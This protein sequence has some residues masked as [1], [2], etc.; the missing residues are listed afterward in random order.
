MKRMLTAAILAVLVFSL[1]SFSAS[2][3]SPPPAPWFIVTL[4]SLP[5]GTVYVDMLISLPE[6]DPCYREINPENLPD[7]FP[8]DAEIIRYC[9]DGYRSY[10]FH[11]ADA[12]SDITPGTSLTVTFCHDPSGQRYPNHIEDIENRGD[13]RL[14]ML[15]VNGNILKVSA[16]TPRNQH[17]FLASITNTFYYN[18]ATDTLTRQTESLL[19]GFLGVLLLIGCTIA[20]TVILEVVTGLA[21]GLKKYSWMILRVNLVSQV[22]M[23][24]LFLIFAMPAFLTIPV[25]VALEIGIY[26]LEYL[27]YRNQIQDVT[28]KKCL[29]Y[30]LT[31]N[32]V[33]LIFGP[34]LLF[35]IYRILI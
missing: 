4:E 10:T 15:D 34:V 9:Q 20:V 8:E 33:S 22:I 16:C 18:A 24:L 6:D 32:T 5:E 29:I 14:A 13:L 19:D 2:A 7:G 3:N 1:L 17:T 30:T 12:A 27:Y 11:Y 35:V 28:R 25:T 31:A 26:V 21:F 23:W